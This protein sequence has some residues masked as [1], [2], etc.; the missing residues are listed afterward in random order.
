[1]SLPSRVLDLLE[2]YP[3]ELTDA[4]LAEL[5]SE[6]EKDTRLHEAMDAV[7]EIDSAIAGL[8]AAAIRPSPE[9]QRRLA[10]LLKS[11]S[12]LNERETRGW[13]SSPAAPLEAK[14]SSI[15]STLSDRSLRWAL[16]ALLVL[17]A[18]FLAHALLRSPPPADLYGG[19][20]KGGSEHRATPLDR[21]LI[22]QPV[23]GERLRDGSEQPVDRPVRITARLTSSAS[24]ALIEVRGDLSA[25]V[26]PPHGSVW[27]GAVGTNL[28]QPPGASPEYHPA[29]SGTTSYVLIG[30]VSPLTISSQHLTEAEVLASNPGASVLDRIT[31]RWT[32][33]TPP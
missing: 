23:G 10:L 12:P 11:A 20:I 5:R 32:H 30:R 8:P 7:L 28:L 25:V 18:G 22:L 16:A 31:I 29:Q 19:G 26:W 33:V 9:A 13:G 4:E 3:D 14:V 2:R 27:L 1:M 6:A 24:L 21:A 15:R 17:A